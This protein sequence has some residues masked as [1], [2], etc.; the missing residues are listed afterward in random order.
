MMTI[1]FIL[2][3]AIVAVLINVATIWAVGRLSRHQRDMFGS[4]WR[5]IHYLEMV[6]GYHD[7]VPMPWEMDEFDNNET[8]GFKREG[9]IVYLQKEE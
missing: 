4:L 3:I 8:K 2:F 6:L 9:N 7:L 1:E 5:R